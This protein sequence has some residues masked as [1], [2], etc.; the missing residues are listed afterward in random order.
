MDVSP[1]T[2]SRV[3]LTSNDIQ[4]LQQSG[5]TARGQPSACSQTERSS[6]AYGQGDASPGP[7]AC[8]DRLLSLSSTHARGLRVFSWL[9]DFP[10]WLFHSVYLFTNWLPGLAIVDRTAINP[11]AQ[12]FVWT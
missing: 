12:V 4:T 7:E 6:A 1:T 10:V 2:F 9:D 5:H 11:H 8:S 3:L